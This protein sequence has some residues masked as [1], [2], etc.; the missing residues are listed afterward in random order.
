MSAVFVR[1]AATVNYKTC[2]TRN[3]GLNLVQLSMAVASI[4]TGPIMKLAR[5]PPA[6]LVVHGR[7]LNQVSVS[8]VSELIDAVGD[9][10]VD[11]IL[12]GA[13]AYDF[14]S[15][16]CGTSAVC[17]NR[18][19][20]IEAQV[21]GSVVFDAKGGRRVFEIQSGGTAELIGLD[22]TGGS[23]TSTQGGGL[24]ISGTA[25]LTNTNVYSNTARNGGG[26]YV[27]SNGV[28]YLGGC[29]IHDNT[30]GWRGGGLN[31]WGTATL[32]NTNVYSN[33]ATTGG[34]GGGH[35]DSNG[36]AN[37]EGCNIHD[38]TAYGLMG[39][40]LLIDGTASLT[41]TNVSSNTAQQGGGGLFIR[42]G[43]TATLTN[44]NVYENRADY[45]CPPLEPSL[46][47]HPLSNVARARSF[48]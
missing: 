13:G 37:F 5:A 15:D 17:I 33:T 39:G 16:M 29:N 8:T 27:D 3:R 6:P 10:G 30:G 41:N 9:S 40:A 48:G 12:V 32:T 11:K 24:L 36:V 20:T 34:G 42:E 1:C 44:T 23:A 47:S 26:V 45:V 2:N 25:T 35:I 21:P 7:K 31:I 4:P 19:L 46:S 14:T 38:N 22:I 18:A 43:R 28:A